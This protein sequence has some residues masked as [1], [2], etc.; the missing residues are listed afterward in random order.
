MFMDVV[1]EYP[2]I[3][4]HLTLFNA[5]ITEG[6]PKMSEHSDIKWITS[7]EISDY[8]F[9]PAYKEILKNIIEVHNG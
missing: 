9:C 3:T 8:E 2:D 5:K 6:V 7:D 1:H 4:V